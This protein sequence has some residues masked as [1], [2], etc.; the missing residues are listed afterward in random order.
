MG[1]FFVV[2]FPNND[3][4]VV[5]GFGRKGHVGGYHKFLVAKKKPCKT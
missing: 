4:K 1:I 5:L 3:R 2:V